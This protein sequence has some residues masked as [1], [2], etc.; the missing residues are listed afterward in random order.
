MELVATRTELS[1]A[2]MRTPDAPGA[3]WFTVFHRRGPDDALV[4]MVWGRWP[5]VQSILLMLNEDRSE[6]EELWAASRATT[7]RRNRW[8][9][10]DQPTRRQQ[11]E[12]R[13]PARASLTESRLSTSKRPAEGEASEGTNLVRRPRRASE[14]QARELVVDTLRASGARNTG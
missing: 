5:V 10:M 8:V 4:G 2:L 7:Q 11:A 12:G 3:H 13:A 9:A 14:V 6:Q 1:E